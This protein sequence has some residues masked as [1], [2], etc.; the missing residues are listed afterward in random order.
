MLRRPRG[1]GSLARRGRQAEQHQQDRAGDP[2]HDHVLGDR[3]VLPADQGHVSGRWNCGRWITLV[4]ERD[5]D[6]R[7]N[8]G[9][10]AG[11]GRRDRPPA[12][13]GLR[14]RGRP[15]LRSLTA[16]DPLGRCGLRPAP[17]SSADAGPQFALSGIAPSTSEGTNRSR[18]TAAER[19]RRTTRRGRARP[20]PCRAMAA[21]SAPPTEAN[22]RASIHVPSATRKPEPCRPCCPRH[23]DAAGHAGHGHDRP[24]R[25][26]PSVQRRAAAGRR[27]GQQRQPRGH[28][29]GAADD[30]EPKR[31][32]RP[33]CYSPSGSRLAGMTL[34][35]KL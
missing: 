12:R 32:A 25:Q 20:P 9:C 31:S 16:C 17:A 14:P 30:R 7:W 22:R 35:K 8:P 24:A 1:T 4:G 3:D 10:G 34:R 11:S 15:R 2:H 6:R 28:G 23:P 19:S 26:S 33:Q 21:P 5:L 13:R 27:Q 18:T 29:D